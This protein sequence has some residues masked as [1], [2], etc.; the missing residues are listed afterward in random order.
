MSEAQHE[1]DS[2][3]RRGL[4]RRA[5]TVAA[6]VAGA[7]VVG[8]AGATPAQA[9]AGDPVVQGA[10]NVVDAAT[11]LRN[12]GARAALR[13]QSVRTYDEGPGGR[14]QAEPALQLMP[15]GSTLSNV[16]EAGSIGM[17]MQGNIWIVTGAS[18][19]GNDRHVVH[20]TAN[21]N[22]IVPLVPQRVLDTRYPSSR[23]LVRE[24]GY[25]DASGRVLAGR[26]ISLRLTDHLYYADAVFGTL[27]VV[28]P[29]LGGFAQVYPFGTTRPTDFSSINYAPNQIVS[30]AF[31][32][33]V[34]QDTDMST[35]ATDLISIYTNRTT[36]LILDITAAVV[37]A[38]RVN[39]RSA[40]PVRANRIDLGGRPTWEK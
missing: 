5:G 9:A 14:V 25:L 35:W 28:Q 40:M 30:N 2:I 12:T 37:G 34:G 1:Q 20:T 39:P 31:V 19:G 10:T 4:L 15:S 33:G 17:D 8:A 24:T 18:G 38:G 3:A 23:A 27:T 16:A 6:G 22:R 32:C 11:T 29:T 13:L 26:S 7:G 21:S 36:H